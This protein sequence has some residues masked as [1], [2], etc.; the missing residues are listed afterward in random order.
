[1]YE[2]RKVK[3]AEVLAS[4]DE[5]ALLKSQFINKYRMPVVSISMNIAGEIKRNPLIDLAFNYGYEMLVKELGEPIESFVKRDFTGCFAVL[6]FD[7]EA[8]YIKTIC[9]E[10]EDSV[11]VGRLLDLDVTDA[12]GTLL[13]RPDGKSRNCLVCG[14]PVFECSRARAHGLYE[15]ANKTQGILADFAVSE[16]SKLAVDA[17]KDELELTPKPGLVDQRNCG[18]HSDMDFDMMLRS[19]E[20]LKWYFAS[21]LRIG[22]NGDLENPSELIG[23]KKLGISA[24]KKMML[25]TGQVNTHRGA[26]YGMGIL[27]AAFGAC[28]KD[29]GSLAYRS[30]K[31]AEGLFELNMEM[32]SFVNKGKL[33]SKSETNKSSNGDLA[34]EIYGACGAENEAIDGFP[35]AFAGAEYL[36]TLLRNCGEDIS[37]AKLRCFVYILAKADDSNL[38]HRGGCQGLQF[39]KLEASR[40]MNLDD[41]RLIEALEALDDKF[42]EK[43]LSPGGTADIFAQSLFLY[44]IKRCID[45]NFS[46]T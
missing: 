38:I 20:S 28:L 33:A 45:G 25:V 23:L 35:T 19:A 17:L 4:R 18:A 9:I 42:I 46:Q 39:A 13:R 32:D 6:T 14:G 31:I 41:A 7:L 1:M 12:S 3:L 24:E 8:E 21:T 2:L 43:N 30:G 44:K 40:L 16:I 5:R 26:I 34:R 10:I 37:I 27:L 29:G 11:P 22:L 36:D 15:I